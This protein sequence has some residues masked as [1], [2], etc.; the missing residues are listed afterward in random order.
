MTLVPQSQPV[1]PVLNVSSAATSLS[2]LALTSLEEEPTVAPTAVEEGITV[3][4][5]T[6]ASEKEPKGAGKEITYSKVA[7]A[8]AASEKSSKAFLSRKMQKATVQA[9]TK[10]NSK[11]LGGSQTSS[12]SRHEI[13]RERLSTD[14][15]ERAMLYQV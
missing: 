14:E 8:A 6:A 3:K 10:S 9:T 12:T 7:T 13:K 5:T 1:S 11:I 15:H 4:T 2:T